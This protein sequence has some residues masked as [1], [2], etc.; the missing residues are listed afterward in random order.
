MIVD[1]IKQS[2]IN[3]NCAKYAY[4]FSNLKISFSFNVYTLHI[5]MYTQYMYTRMHIHTHFIFLYKKKY[6]GQRNRTEKIFKNFLINFC[7]FSGK[8]FQNKRI[9][10]KILLCVY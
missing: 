5:Y 4:L 10:R 1:H 3:H 9:K 7:N 8:S 6:I 2:H